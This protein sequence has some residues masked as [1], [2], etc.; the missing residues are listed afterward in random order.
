MSRILKFHL[1]LL[2][3][4]FA[5]DVQAQTVRWTIKPDY[6]SV[7]MCAD[8]LYKVK[9]GSKYGILN[10]DGAEVVPVCMDVLTSF[11]EGFALALNNEGA[12]YRL[13][14][15]IG[16]NGYYMP[17][18]EEWYVKDYPF[19]SEGKLPVYNIRGRYGYIDS[20]GRVV[21]DFKYFGIHPFSEGF[22][23]VTTVKSKK[24][25]VSYINERG[26]TLN[27]NEVG[28]I[29]FG[30]TFKNGEALVIPKDGSHIIINKYGNILGL[31]KSP[32]KRFDW[33]NSLAD[34]PTERIDDKYEPE[35]DNY[36]ATF[37]LGEKWGYRTADFV[38]LPPQFDLAYPFSKGYAVVSVNG[39]EG[40]LKLLPED[41]SFKTVSETI[42][43]DGSGKKSVVYSVTVPAEWQGRSLTLK[44]DVAG[45]SFHQNA[46]G[47]DRKEREFSFTL[48]EGSRVLTLMGDGIVL[49]Q[50]EKVEPVRP[51]SYKDQLKVS[52]SPTKVKANHKDTASVGVSVTNLSQS[53]LNVSVEARIAGVRLCTYEC[54]LTG[55]EKSKAKYA[56]FSTKGMRKRE[57]RTVSV[58]VMV[59][60][61]GEK[62]TVN[63]KIEIEPFFME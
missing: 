4:F 16:D 44:C 5:V 25:K 48:A 60:E 63:R 52:V 41:F 31:D 51:S 59:K 50:V 32:S 39:K 24:S 15:I 61:T 37:S 9:K 6:D 55:G 7:E 58:T 8:G 34:G 23:A 35:Y 29:Y 28:A 30:S 26:E 42:S 13:K 54:S 36:P 27:L 10:K 43:S 57:N 45:I 22:A 46:V 62:F 18:Y 21:L 3:L 40:L 1:F 56:S 49:K 47:N 12:G 53:H 33:K 38:I 20:S 11:S 17:V 14:G 19:F 2:V